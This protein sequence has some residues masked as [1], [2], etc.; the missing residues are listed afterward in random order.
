MVFQHGFDGVTQKSCVV[1]RQGRDDQNCRLFFDGVERDGIVRKTLEA[2]KF[3]K[4]FVN[5]DAL[6]NGN[7][8]L[9]HMDRANAKFGLDIVFAKAVH[10]FIASGNTLRQRRLA[11]GVQRIAVHLGGRLGQ[12]CKWL[13]DGALSFVDLVKHGL[14]PFNLLH[15]SNI[16]VVVPAKCSRAPNLGQMQDKQANTN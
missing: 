2:T 14:K 1:A 13:H 6:M 10:Q 11:N 9:V 16:S 15:C 4:W 5:F 8:Y 7:I 12:V 3:A